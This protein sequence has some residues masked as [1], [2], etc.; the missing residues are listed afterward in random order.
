MAPLGDDQCGHC[1]V[2]ERDRYRGALQEI[3]E[4][5]KGT[6]WRGDVRRVTGIIGILQKHGFKV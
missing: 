3:A 1:L 4:V 6:D 5:V 2:A